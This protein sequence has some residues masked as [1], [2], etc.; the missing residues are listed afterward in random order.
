[1]L[2]H[3]NVNNAGERVAAVVSQI[4]TVVYIG[5]SAAWLHACYFLSFVSYD[6]LLVKVDKVV[7]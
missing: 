6:D 2:S 7:V 3:L 5:D 4:Q 1:M